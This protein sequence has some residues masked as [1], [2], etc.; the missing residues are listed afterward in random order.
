M[1]LCVL[2]K[3]QII[4]MHGAP[5]I[6]AMSGLSSKQKQAIRIFLKYGIIKCI[7]E[8]AYQTY[9][10]LGIPLLVHMLLLFKH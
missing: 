1:T 8:M 3:V 5:H 2:I 7:A 10:R 9:F 4:V 6:A